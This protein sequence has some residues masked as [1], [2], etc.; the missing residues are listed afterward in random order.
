MTIQGILATS[1]RL[2]WLILLLPV[3]G[4]QQ[5]AFDLTEWEEKWSN[6]E[7]R[8][9]LTARERLVLQTEIVEVVGP[10][11]EWRN[12]TV[13]DWT[14]LVLDS[15]ESSP[16]IEY[17]RDQ[18]V[19]LLSAIGFASKDSAEELAD[20]S[21]LRTYYQRGL[22]ISQSPEE[23]GVLLFHIAA[24]L[25]RSEPDSL[26][27]RRR[28]EAFIQQALGALGNAPPRD[29]VHMMLANL[30]SDWE[31]LPGGAGANQF[32]L[33]RAAAQCRAVLRMPEARDEYRE[34]AQAKLDE[35]L[36]PGIQLT[37]DK[38]FLPQNNIRL[39]TQ[40]RNVGEIDVEVYQLPWQENG[41]AR[42]LDELKDTLSRSI[43][44]PATMVFR[45]SFRIDQRNRIDWQEHGLLLGEGFQSG[46]YQVRIV[47]PGTN[48][49]DLLFVSSID[50][51]V[52]PRRDGSLQLWVAEVDSGAPV[53]NA[54]IDILDSA[55]SVLERTSSGNDGMVNIPSDAARNW[56]EIHVQSGENAALVENTE[57]LWL[58]S[59]LPWIIS[60]NVTVRPGEML[61]WT[62]VA[63]PD[64]LSVEE[65]R[66]MT[67]SLPDG[68]ILLPQVEQ[69][70]PGLWSGSVMIP[71]SSSNPG[72]V[73]IQLSSEAQLLISHL[74]RA[75]LL[76]M[77][78]ELAGEAFSRKELLF[79]GSSQ[80]EVRVFNNL[81]DDG[82]IPDYIR[83]VVSTVSRQPIKVQG[84]GVFGEDE[85]I[86]YENIF[87]IG[88]SST[89]AAYFELTGLEQA[90]Q[91]AVYRV[92]IH[93]LN[94]EG[95]L[96]EKYFAIVP[97]VGQV[98]LRV[99]QH[100]L[101]EGESTFVEIAVPGSNDEMLRPPAGELVLY[102][103]TWESR[104]LHRKRGTII[105][106]DNYL[107][108]PERSLLGS[109]K[110]DYR[111]LEEG[112][113]R[114]EVNRYPVELSAS[115]SMQVRLDRPG[116]YNMEF[117]AGDSD[118]QPIYPEGPLEVWVV[119]ENGDL[120]SF[121]SDK[122]RMIVEEGDNGA[123]EILLLVEDTGASILVDLEYV[124]G[125]TS[126]IVRRSETSAL[127]IEAPARDSKVLACRAVII[128]GSQTDH[129]YQN[130]GQD[131]GADW[132]QMEGT[133]LG[134]NPGSDFKLKLTGEAGN[135]AIP[136]LWSFFPVDA[137]KVVDGR[138]SF[139][140]RLH[141][142]QR[143]SR[144]RNMLSFGQFL[145]LSL[146][147]EPDTNVQ[148]T[149]LGNVLLADPGITAVVSLFPE[150]LQ[151]D[152]TGANQLNLA[153]SD[154]FEIDGNLPNS[155]GK[156]N[157]TVLGVS[158]Q[159]RLNWASW[160]VSTELPI[161]TSLVGPDLVRPGDVPTFSLAVENTT[162]ARQVLNMSLSASGSLSLST[163]DLIENSFRP[164]QRILFP[165]ATTAESAG[166]GGVA[167]ETG[168][169][170][171]SSANLQAEVARSKSSPYLQMYKLDE[172]DEGWKLEISLDG[173]TSGRVIAGAGLGPILREVWSAMRSG[174][175][176]S[177][178]L[179]VALGDWAQDSVDA[180]HGIIGT[181]DPAK[182]Q[183]L[184]DLLKVR[185]GP[186]G[187]WSWSAGHPDD[188]WLTAMVL[189]SL[190][191]FSHSEDAAITEVRENARSFL[192]QAMVAER[193]DTDARLNALR[194][195]AGPAF[196]SQARPSRI[197]AKAFLEFLH[198]RDE[199]SNSQMA[200]LLQIA[201]AYGF[202]EEVNLLAEMLNERL[203]AHGGSYG[204]DFWDH[205]L[206][207]FSLG[208]RL[209][210]RAVRSSVLDAAYD[211]LD[212][213][214]SLRGWKTVGGYLN[215]LGAFLL[216]GDF[217]IGG[218][219][220]MSVSGRGRFDFPLNP[221]SPSG[222]FAITKLGS[223]Q[224]GE[225]RAL[226]ELH[227]LIGSDPLTVAV[228]GD[229]QS[230]PVLDPYPEQEEEILREFVEQTL[231]AGSRIQLRGVSEA[232]VFQ[233][234]D[235]VQVHLSLYVEAPRHFAEFQFS[236][237]GG[238][239]LATDSIQH[240][241][242]PSTSDS[243]F[244]EPLI[245]LF[246]QDDPL[247]QVL[248]M[249]PLLPGRHDFILSYAVDWAGDYA[250]PAH[251]V[252]FPDS[253]EAFSLGSSWRLRIENAR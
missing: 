138:L 247:L 212:G 177:E 112:F 92:E 46:F 129:L 118:Y 127:Y 28:V 168:G 205:T 105:S 25:V 77:S 206:I 136:A 7:T 121:R 243:I 141:L 185:Q 157:L 155:I 200:M 72:P 113:V 116:Y 147:F 110:T 215:L 84:A 161:R 252:I 17:A 219:A 176:D 14:R 108:L 5:V 35:L 156:W 160:P 207:Y 198:V 39:T 149:D 67:V 69:L 56:S 57:G 179:L 51:S 6:A 59:D 182:W 235:T 241:I 123:E 180:F 213:Q 30:Y 52:I 86:V 42:I 152:L 175:E 97:Y 47:G 150:L 166:T 194:S 236:I 143:L 37:I 22:S 250:F 85:R 187:G 234:G 81:L 232:T 117:E 53:E 231:L 140:R 248:R 15:W 224:I 216:E 246:E 253:G 192:E 114:E 139:Q 240:S 88:S 226:V 64:T 163:P 130:N 131:N 124:D 172:S 183:R 154:P 142:A 109:A 153:G 237:P 21:L 95:L 132:R 225:G 249:E 119:P 107:K 197:Q 50:A 94:E 251:K 191:T 49:D 3:L 211:H 199:L 171:S 111:L 128:G 204:Q 222:G 190:E 106:E 169:R 16:D 71:S 193:L 209:E 90:G 99:D 74:E 33:G 167:V 34:R 27:T 62:M 82:E 210:S 196:K 60:S 146:P 80:V 9:D 233:P 174:Q 36:K 208:E 103:E 145:S 245:S 164:G 79:M 78:I 65:F 228:I 135:S 144:S 230:P 162:L 173:W 120:R 61:G 23:E 134:L 181:A 83:V 170:F 151:E 202:L 189:W 48:V 239:T 101:Q 96:G 93:P 115:N 126:T 158:G 41:S 68:S 184:L 40:T 91:V 223:Q 244:T 73:S 125:H 44:D 32:N 29:A 4:A 165:I 76:P 75:D 220:D 195:L 227:S 26:E 221:D 133:S 104:Y 38:R 63:E 87:N 2:G 20:E 8:E 242:E 218:S 70:G 58:D 55:G 214:V 10:F 12:S 122:R 203:A 229:V 137:E 31:L 43:P 148:S 45:K 159:N 188:L 186:E 13:W 1:I 98:E 89:I 18:Y 178:P 11:V 66:E 100:I 102:R 201:R 54:G 24:S 19:S 217:S 238:A